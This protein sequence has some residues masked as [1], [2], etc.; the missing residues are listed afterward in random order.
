EANRGFVIFS[1]SGANAGQFSPVDRRY[2]VDLPAAALP[3]A[4]ENAG[5]FVSDVEF[6]ENGLHNADRGAGAPR[7]RKLFAALAA[8]LPHQV[9]RCIANFGRDIE[10][11][12]SP[13]GVFTRTE[14]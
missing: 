1:G 6:F 13:D 5:T 2:L 7:C 11:G 9:H 12:P 14:S 4:A 8:A 3:F 10:S